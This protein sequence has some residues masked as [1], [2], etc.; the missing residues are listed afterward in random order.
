[1]SEKVRM[2]YNTMR[3]MVKE[4]KDAKQQLDETIGVVTKLGKEMEDDGLKGQAGQTFVGALNG[5]L[6]K[7]LKKL[8]A[9]MGEMADEVEKAR[10]AL[11]DGV[12]D[13]KAKFI[14]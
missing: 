13:A 4:F 5:P 2:N 1:M 14:N 8:S 6:V 10:A 12:K 11:E 9:K 3:D 7:S